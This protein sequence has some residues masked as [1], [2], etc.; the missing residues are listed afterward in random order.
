[1]I[2]AEYANA[3]SEVL[4][5]LKYISKEDYNKIPATKLEVF[6][7]NSNKNYFFTYNPNKTL[8]EQN[9]SKR[10]K[11]IISILFRD[12]WST[13]QQKEKILRKQNYDRQILEETKKALFNVDNLFEKQNLKVEENNKEL[14]IYKENLFTKFIK[15]MKLLF[16]KEK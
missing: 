6:K 12:Y 16:K 9:V 10:A 1:M 14:I 8:N 15:K 4:E 13:E 7:R 5:I 3:Y 2:N 11:A